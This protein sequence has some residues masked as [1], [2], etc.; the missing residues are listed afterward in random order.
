MSKQSDPSAL[1]RAAG[2]PE[3]PFR[4]EPVGRRGRHDGW[5][6]EKQVAFIDALAE[7]GCVVEA[8]ARIGMSPSSAYA[9][10]RSPDAISF[11]AAWEAALDHAISRL[12]DSAFSRAINGVSRPVFF[13]GQQIGERRHFDERL[14]MFLLRYRDPLHYAKTLDE[15][16]YKGSHV[17]AAYRLF[18]R[19]QQAEDD[20]WV[21]W[22]E[23]G[24]D[25]GED[26][27][28]G[29]VP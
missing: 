22:V 17:G 23:D 3:R 12:S 4:F 8:C 29:D 9:L 25:L 16:I 24:H 14:T 5:T 6:P 7:C 15:M 1:A 2:A 20:A 13:Q 11:R 18:R 19:R 27:I 10:R 21:A 26:G 28:E